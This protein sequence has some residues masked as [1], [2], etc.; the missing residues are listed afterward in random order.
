MEQNVVSCLERFAVIAAKMGER[1]EELSV[2]EAA[3]KAID[4]MTDLA[5][6]INVPTRLRDLEIPQ[7]AIPQLAKDAIKQQRLLSQNPRAFTEKDIES[8]YRS[9]W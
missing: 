6:D 4:A 3:F 1:V 2:R 5:N 7:D 9:A 8:I